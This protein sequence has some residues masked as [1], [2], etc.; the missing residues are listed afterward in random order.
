MDRYVISAR[1][2]VVVIIVYFLFV[3]KTLK[4]RQN[5]PIA[6]KCI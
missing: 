6:P 1:T 3:L 2:D 5:R 4:T